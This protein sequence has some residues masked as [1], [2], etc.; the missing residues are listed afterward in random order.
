MRDRRGITRR[1]V[2]AQV[3][4]AP[5]LAPGARVVVL[6]EGAS[7]AVAVQAAAR[8]LGC[9]LG[10]VS[11]VSAAG[12]G[13]IGGL[14]A[15]YRAEGV[16]LRGLCDAAEVPWVCQALTRAGVGIALDRAGLERLGFFI[17]DRDLEDELIRALGVER[18]LD[19]IAAQGDQAAFATLQRQRAWR[20]AALTDQI[21]RF[22]GAGAGRKIR[23]A[24]VFVQEVALERMPGPLRAVLDLAQQKPAGAGILNL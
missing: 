6:V 11:V 5:V 10:G 12:V 23:Y 17:C 8:R 24:G 19:L 13:N 22:L 14:A 1:R 15:Q 9:D 7:D 3:P 20:D 2:V 4:A 16:Q 18:V 21:R